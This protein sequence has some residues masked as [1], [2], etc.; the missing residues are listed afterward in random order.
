MAQIRV[1]PSANGWRVTKHGQT[2]S[3]HRKKSRAKQ[4]A[5][6]LAG[7]G[8]TVTIHRSNGTIQTTRSY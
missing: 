5:K 3:R 1:K 6:R 2:K 8:D 4:K 7:S